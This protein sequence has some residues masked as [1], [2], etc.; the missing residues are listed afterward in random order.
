QAG[1]PPPMKPGEVLLTIYAP[2]EESEEWAPDFFA[3]EGEPGLYFQALEKQARDTGLGVV[4]ECRTLALPQGRSEHRFADVAALIDPTTVHFVDQT[5]P[6]GTRVVEQNFFYDLATGQTLLQRFLGRPIEFIDPGGESHR[7]T[8]LAAGPP[9]VLRLP[10]GSIEMIAYYGGLGREDFFGEPYEPRWPMGTHAFRF[11]ELPDDLVTRPTLGWTVHAAK[12]G[13]H[14]VVV[15]YQTGG[16]TWR[17]DYAALLSEDESRIDLSGWV[18]IANLCGTRFADA[19]LKLFAGEV[20]RA[21]RRQADSLGEDFFGDDEGY[22]AEPPFEQKPFFEYHLYTLRG[23]TTLENKQTKQIEFVN[24]RGVPVK[25]VYTY[26]GLKD[27]WLFGDFQR[28]ETYGT[29]CRKTVRVNLEVENREAAG[30]G[31]PLPAGVVRVFKTDE[32]DGRREFVGEDRIG[33]TP[34]DETVRLYIGDAFDLVGERVR[35]DYRQP[36]FHQARESFAIELRNHKDA[37][38]TIYVLEHLYRG[39]NWKVE[40]S[41]LPFE[42]LDAQSIQFQPTVPAHGRA[43]VTYTV[44]YWW[45]KDEDAF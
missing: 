42:K 6:D 16:M 2:S 28:D 36:E 44:L 13:E 33:H 17:S 22:D 30:L 18:T 25:K 10:G 1:E 7:G 37:P 27:H 26:D 8:L 20:R 12:A 38:V 3:F 32:A 5:D 24:V 40:A 43:T 19:R 41:S 14:D 23:R 15:S 21:R 34:R 45:P 35:T 4:R 11:P 31:I 9:L 39:I 29:Q